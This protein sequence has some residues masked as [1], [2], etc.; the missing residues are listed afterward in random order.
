MLLNKKIGLIIFC[1]WLNFGFSQVKVLDLSQVDSL[2]KIQS[3]PI[4]VL[5]STDWCS[6]CKVQKQLVQKNEKFNA[7]AS[8][9]YYV[10]FDAESNQTIIFNNKNFKSTNKKNR[11]QTHELAL[12]LFENSKPVYPT[13]LLLDSEYKVKF[14]HHGFLK[15]KFLDELVEKI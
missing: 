3:K 12:F 5:L 8:T 11:K 2:M 7:K 9:F 10:E 4:L 6:Y 14:K 13:W 15:P 1:V